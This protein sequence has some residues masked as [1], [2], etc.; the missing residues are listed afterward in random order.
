MR[1]SVRLP[2]SVGGVNDLP[3][4]PRGKHLTYDRKNYKFAT[5]NNDKDSIVFSPASL[6]IPSLDKLRFPRSFKRFPICSDNAD[7]LPVEPCELYC[8]AEKRVLVLLV[9]CGE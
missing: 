5:V 7:F 2:I 9:V 1:G 3:E 6:E 8:H 4:R